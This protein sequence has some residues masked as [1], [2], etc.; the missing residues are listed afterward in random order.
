MD[1][2]MLLL[3]VGAVTAVLMGLRTVCLHVV[4]LESIPACIVHRIE[5][6]NR[7]APWVVSA[8]VLAC[9]V[10]TAMLAGSHFATGL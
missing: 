7:I 9:L 3:T 1:L 4:D 2:A 6:G 8:A 10:G 5:V